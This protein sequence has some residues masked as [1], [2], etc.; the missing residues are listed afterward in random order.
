MAPHV[1]TLA[2][3]G[4]AILHDASCLVAQRRGDDAGEP[5]KWEF[6]G[7]KVEPGEAPCA[8]LVREIREELGIEIEV[9]A[10][11]GRG[12]SDHGSRRIQLDVYLARRLGGTIR[13]VDHQRYGWF[14]A[15]ELEA[16]DWAAA[17]QPLVAELCALISQPS[18]EF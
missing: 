14:R 10:W 5:R 6:P 1:P 7:G 18:E 11:L 9:G 12:H 8:A 13:L 2:V 3:V 4:A 15:G 17:D 16:L